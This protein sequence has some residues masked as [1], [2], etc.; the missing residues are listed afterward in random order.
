MQVVMNLV[1]IDRI[2]VGCTALMARYSASDEMPSSWAGNAAR[3][4]GSKVTPRTP[5]ARDLVLPHAALGFMHRHP[6]VLPQRR[7]EIGQR[8]TLFVQPVA[9]FVD[10]TEERIEGIVLVESRRHPDVGTGALAER[11]HRHIK[12]VPAG[13]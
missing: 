10:R 1:G 9:G 12:N 7:T 2:R 4:S 3:H 5:A 8:Q 13:S 6:G 11:V